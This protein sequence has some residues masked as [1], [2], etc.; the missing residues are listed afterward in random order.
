MIVAEMS[1]TVRRSFVVVG[2]VQGVMFRQSLIRGAQKLRIRAGAT[3]LNSPQKDR[4]SVTLEGGNSEV[5][6][7]INRLQ[8]QQINSWG[9]RV[10]KIYPQD[11]TVGV[12][13]HQVTTE[14]VDSTW[15]SATHV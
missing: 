13:E 15:V 5:D 12:A 6:D 7:L 8:T 14:N 9:A 2:K 10:K 4:V 3:N 1:A 11:D